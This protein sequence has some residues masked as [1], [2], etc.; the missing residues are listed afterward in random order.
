MNPSFRNYVG[1]LTGL[2]VVN[3]L[4]GGLKLWQGYVSLSASMR[5]TGLNNTA[6]LFYALLLA[7]GLWVSSKPADRTHPEGHGRFESL[8]GLAVSVIIILTG[9]AVVWDGFHRFGVAE[10]ITTDWMGWTLLAASIGLKGGLSAWLNQ[11]GRKQGSFALTAVS[12]DQAADILVDVSVGAAWLSSLYGLH[13]L[14]GLVALGI[15]LFVA[16]IGLDPLVESVHQLTGR[17]PD[18]A[19][20]KKVRSIVSERSDIGNAYGIRAHYVGPSIH[21]SLNVSAPPDLTLDRVHRSEEE[22]RRKL[23]EIDQV[24]RVFIHIEPENEHSPN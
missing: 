13:W 21:L 19:L 2:I 3:F 17:Q 14:D 23:L 22:L 15:G 18:P 5:G 9:L 16:K 10:Q 1:A 12:R 6:D 4:L 24:I 20:V 7:A 11:L 8:L